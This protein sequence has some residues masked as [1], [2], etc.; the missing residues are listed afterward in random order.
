M[1]SETYLRA[2]LSMVARQA[3]P[4]DQLAKIVAP[5]TSQHAQL[6]AYNMCD[7]T[8]S[9]GDIAKASNIDPGNFSRTVARWIDAGALFRIGDARD[10]KLLHLYPL[11]PDVMPKERSK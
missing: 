4:P 8:R 7:G 6:L 9:Q 3:L 10:A 1:S 2:I 11:P 5:S